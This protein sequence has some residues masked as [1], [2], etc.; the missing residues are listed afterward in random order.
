MKVPV[1]YIRC[2]LAQFSF[3]RTIM[4]LLPLSLKPHLAHEFLN[5]LVIDINTISM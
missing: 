5:S 3:I 2:N 4:L 1:D